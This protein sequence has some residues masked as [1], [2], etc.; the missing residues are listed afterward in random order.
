MHA[1]PGSVNSG[2]LT[3]R[4]GSESEVA[5]EST[6]ICSAVAT[7]PGG[8]SDRGP[9]PSQL[10][11]TDHAQQG[12]TPPDPEGCRGEGTGAS[13]SGIVVLASDCSDG[14]D[15]RGGQERVDSRHVLSIPTLGTPAPLPSANRP[16]Q[17]GGVGGRA[18]GCGSGVRLGIKAYFASVSREASLAMH[19]RA[20]SHVSVLQQVVEAR[21]QESIQARRAV[22]MRARKTRR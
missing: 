10:A 9:P 2:A 15:S 16:V 22:G 11:G 18:A 6:R 13:S 3:A 5:H 1:L 17:E 14:G 7:E 4:P 21:H 12:G 19:E 20:A 8:R